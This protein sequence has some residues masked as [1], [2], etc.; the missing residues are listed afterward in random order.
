M[1]LTGKKEMWQPRTPSKCS[2]CNNT[3]TFERLADPDSMK[4]L[5]ASMV[6]LQ[7]VSSKEEKH[8]DAWECM[9]C[10]YVHWTT[11]KKV[12]LT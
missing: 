4:Y 1:A 5:H 12:D 10:G 7:G 2:N 11:R 8:V 9:T 3:T 6:K